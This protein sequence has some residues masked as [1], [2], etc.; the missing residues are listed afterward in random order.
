MQ[1]LNG[2]LLDF[3]DDW[4]KRIKQYKVIKKMS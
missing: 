1:K 2:C 3:Y 4:Q